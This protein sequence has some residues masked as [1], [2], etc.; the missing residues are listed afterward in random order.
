MSCSTPASLYKSILTFSS[1]ILEK[2]TCSNCF[3]TPSALAII[4]SL[5][6]ESSVLQSH[7]FNSC[8]S[9]MTSAGTFPNASDKNL[10]IL[11]STTFSGIPFLNIISQKGIYYT[12]FAITVTITANSHVY[13]NIFNAVIHINSI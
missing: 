12:F 3:S 11:T 5:K 10:A 4:K 13:I 9:S 1:S 8:I 7:S 6:Y 2:I